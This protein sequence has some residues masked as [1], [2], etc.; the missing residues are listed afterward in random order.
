MEASP[1]YPALHRHWL[2]VDDSGALVECG[3]QLLACPYL[4]HSIATHGL[5]S[6]P[7]ATDP[8]KFGVKCYTRSFSLDTPLGPAYPGLHTQLKIVLDD[9]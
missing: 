6:P 3:G 5:H 7:A 4:H 9:S 2:R 8:V 1:K